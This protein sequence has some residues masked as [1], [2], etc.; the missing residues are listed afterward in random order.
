MSLKAP[1][2]AVASACLAILT[3]SNAA[4]S[5]A[6]PSVY[7]WITK[8]VCADASNQPVAADPYDGCPAGTTERDI[9]IGEALPYLNHDQPYTG[10]PD[11]YQRHDAYPVLDK[12][13]N[14]LIVVEMDFGY[15]RPYGTFEA[16]DGDGYDLYSINNGWVSAGG[17][18]DG[19]GYS[20]T[21]WGSGCTDYNG[22]VFFPTSFLSNLTPGAN[23]S[24]YQPIHGDYWEANAEN[25]PGSCNVFSGFDNSTLTTWQFV[26][27]YAF[28]GLNGAPVKNMD[29]IISTH[30]FQNTAQFASSGG[31]EV[32]YFT[33]QYGATRWEAWAPAAQN[34]P[35][36]QQQTCTGPTTM[37][38]QG[39]AFTLVDCRDWSTTVLLSAGWEHPVWPV[40][41]LNRLSNFHFASSLTSWTKVGQNTIAKPLRSTA[42]IDTQVGAGVPYLSLGCGGV[43]RSTQMVYQDIP[44]SKITV[45]L[46]YDFG[47]SAVS[48]G[49]TPGVLTITL[50][51]VNSSGKVL[52]TNAVTA[53]IPTGFRSYTDANSVY[54]AAT[55]TGNTTAPIAIVSGATAIRFAI[56]PQT[57]NMTFDVLDAWV[58]PRGQQ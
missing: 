29:T 48:H 32:F 45:G 36:Q 15:D 28:G 6:L 25:W 27:Q 10:H 4:H 38:Y 5:A 39:M 12:S 43:C 7:D 55:F 24:T 9:Q 50:N 30:G 13:G 57:S 2:A 14:P 11:G 52:Q 51:Q 3:H 16:G 49:T 17:T 56:T 23:G 18:R 40:P 41:D 37:T 31:L 53:T 21:F 44:V 20:Q 46:P 8:D 47:I 42:P 58:M 1:L 19:G 54:R 34:R 35:P 33:K 22:W 26:P